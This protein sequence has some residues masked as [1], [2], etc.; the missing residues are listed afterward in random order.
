MTEKQVQQEIDLAYKL[1]DAQQEENLRRQI[2]I[3]NEEDIYQELQE[4]SKCV[5]Y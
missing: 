5:I 4:T 1:H 3:L 2:E